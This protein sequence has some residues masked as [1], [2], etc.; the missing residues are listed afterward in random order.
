MNDT[1][2]VD[3]KHLKLSILTLELQLTP[4]ALDVGRR[5]LAVVARGLGSRGM[6]RLPRAMLTIAVMCV[7]GP[8]TWIGTP[9][10]LPV[11]ISNGK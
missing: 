5:K 9:S 4:A 8:N 11:T 2:F 6:S 7:S 3:K 1:H 10:V